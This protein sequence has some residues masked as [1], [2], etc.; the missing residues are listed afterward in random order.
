MSKK[1]NKKTA[2]KSLE[3]LKRKQYARGGRGGRGEPEM[4]PKGKPKPQVP[5]P[6]DDSNPPK[7][8]PKKIPNPSG[9]IVAPPTDT[10]IVDPPTSGGPKVSPET[11][12]GGGGYK[13]NTGVAG[14]V[15]PS[16][17]SDP[18]M[19][20]GGR[21][22]NNPYGNGPRGGTPPPQTE[23]QEPDPT[24]LDQQDPASRGS[25]SLPE[26]EIGNPDD[27]LY[28]TPYPT[29]T[30]P[31]NPGPMEKQAI[32]DWNAANTGGTEAGPPIGIEIEGPQANLRQME[33]VDIDPETGI[34]TEIEELEKATDAT[35]STVVSEDMITGS[36]NVK[37]ADLEL[38]DGTA[39]S[40]EAVTAGK[41]DPTKA[42]QGKV[43]EVGVSTDATA[44]TVDTAQRDP[45]AE[46]AAMGT[47]ADRPPEQDYAKAAL[48]DERFEII[49]AQDPE[50]A[51]RMAQ[52]MSEREQ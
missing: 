52:T 8:K 45:D 19:G 5:A 18:D 14:G 46:E 42:A 51:A 15:D 41:L 16:L 29:P 35:T 9:P 2:N 11:V 22:D 26:Q 39:E 7:P 31:A 40:Y 33:S 25:V 1:G 34:S 27:P 20:G 21:R 28:G 49:Q 3:T 47:A 50:V 30:N 48:T 23:G 12:E 6:Y 10:V 43:S 13:E 37:T 32:K 24:Y 4:K 38:G 36:G 17:Y 44:T